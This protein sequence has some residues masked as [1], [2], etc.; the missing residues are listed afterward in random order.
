MIISL[1]TIF[2]FQVGIEIADKECC[3]DVGILWGFTIDF[4]IIRFVFMK[5]KV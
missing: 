2:G 1:Q 4:F 3:E 5:E